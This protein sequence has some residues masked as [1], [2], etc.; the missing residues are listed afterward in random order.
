M[1][2]QNGCL[3]KDMG[4]AETPGMTEFEK[5]SPA[6][7]NLGNSFRDIPYCMPCA[8]FAL[9]TAR[10]EQFIFLETEKMLS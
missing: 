4:V 6:S 8:R 7:S 1:I 5:T 2:R 9:M 10:Q 3:E